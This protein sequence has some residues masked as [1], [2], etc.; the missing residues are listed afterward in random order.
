MKLLITAFSFLV[1]LSS[2]KNNTEVYE[3]QESNNATAQAETTHPGKKLME[4]HCYVCHSPERTGQQNR[5]APPMAMVQKHYL[6]TNTTKEEFIKDFM[7]FLEK[8]S[9]DLSKMP[10]AIRN[11]GLMPYQKF[12]QEALEQIADYL[13]E[14]NPLDEMRQGRQGKGMRRGMGQTDTL[15]N[16]LEEKAVIGLEFALETKQLLGQNLMSILQKEGTLH[17]LEFCNIE[18]IPLTKQME[19]KN[20]AVIKRVSDK[21]RNPNNAA[22]EEE[23]YYIAHFQ[24]EIAA[25][26]DPKP[27]VLP[28]GEQTRFYYPIVTNRMCLQCHGHPDKIDLKVLDKIYELYPNDL[29]TAY[30]ENEVRGIWSIVF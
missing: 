14:Q 8:P 26:N 1:L 23:K 24:K 22:N 11:F 16:T 25:G 21:N 12:P 3:S 13:Y 18:A 30:E 17:A 20:K 4:T 19:E 7:A 28:T 27:V 6:N 9:E 10:G 2:C 29:A 15:K 5:I